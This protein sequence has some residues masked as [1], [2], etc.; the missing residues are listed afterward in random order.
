MSGKNS[1]RQPLKTLKV[2]E[3]L[4]SRI[5]KKLSLTGTKIQHFVEE[6]L[7]KGLRKL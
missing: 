3:D 2:N 6:H 5:K 4:H 1:Q 7:E